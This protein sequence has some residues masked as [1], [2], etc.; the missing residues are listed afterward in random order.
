MPRA[1]LGQGGRMFGRQAYVGLASQTYGTLTFGRQY[2]PTIDMFSAISAS[3]QAGM[4]Q[5]NA[6]AT[7][8]DNDNTD[9]NF[10]VNNSVKYL[11]PTV[12]G[13][14]GEALY[15]FSN[16]DGFAD[17]RVISMAGQYK[18]GGLTAVAAYM[19][20][21]NPGLGTAGAVTNDAVFTG[22]AQENLDAGLSYKYKAMQIA[23]TWSHTSIDDPTSNIYLP[24]SIT[25][26]DGGAWTAWKFDNFQINGAYH[27]TPFFW[28]AASYTYTLGRLDTTVGEY[29][30]KWHTAQL[31]LNYD[32][33][34]RT[35]V[36]A[37][38]AYQHVQSANTGTFFDN[39]QMMLAS[40]P[41]STT[42]QFVYRI[43][44][45]HRF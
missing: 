20:I 21:D 23:F 43:A 26:S 11:S 34:A 27:I 22:A 5:G 13:F 40:G 8:F 31:T 24:G 45:I 12:G 15:G 44:I 4:P 29:S 7:P 38:A 17:N 18:Y 25:P 33:S 32:L 2:D 9:W 39:A 14:T 35:S 37:Q 6:G 36:Y 42:N 16:A 30:P 41:S 19:K 3:S 28:A 10:R 1:L